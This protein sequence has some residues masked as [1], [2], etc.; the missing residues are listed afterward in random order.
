[1]LRISRDNAKDG[2]VILRLEGEISG[3]WVDETSRLCEGIIANGQ[4][5]RIDLADV[6]FADRTGVELLGHLR[7]RRTR[8][9]HCS[10]F[11][12]ARLELNASATDV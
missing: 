6:T 2:S 1:M 9:D 5:L 11:L 12:R 4:R 10:P 3:P 8:L 7:T